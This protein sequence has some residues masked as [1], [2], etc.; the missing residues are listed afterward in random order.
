ML[1]KS[2]AT[3]GQDRDR[4]NSARFCISA[5]SA[6]DAEQQSLVVRRGPFAKD[7]RRTANDCFT[8]FRVASFR[9][10]PRCLSALRFG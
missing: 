10:L 6:L 7:Q 9:F 5:F 4:V 3:V 1:Q 2:L 8:F